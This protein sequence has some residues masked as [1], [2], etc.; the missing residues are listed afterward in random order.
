M[1]KKN[2]VF[3]TV[4]AVATLLTAVV[5]TTFAYFTATVAGN[6]TAKTTTITTANNLGIT[7]SDGDKITGSSIV[8]GWVSETKHISVTN[9]GDA[10]V[11]YQI[12]WADVTNA[13]KSY[14]TNSTTYTDDLVY[15]VVETT[16]G[17][18]TV[19]TS[20]AHTRVTDAAWTK[21]AGKAYSNSVGTVS[22]GTSTVET[23]VAAVPATGATTA[24][25]SNKTIDKNATQTF[26]VTVYFVETGIAQ[27]ENQSAVVAAHCSDGTDKTQSEC[28]SPAEWVPATSSISFSGKL[29]ASIVETDGIHSN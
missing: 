27:N 6:D 14:A 21:V 10:A 23:A 11:K 13:F 16:G 29:Q 15:S 19:L 26:D 20:G 25:V 2:V 5:G 18:S 1:E 22:V 3:L 17:T 8:P 9:N 4:L 28:V 12:T 24:I 7:Y